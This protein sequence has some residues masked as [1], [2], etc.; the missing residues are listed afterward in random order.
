MSDADS[1]SSKESPE[2]TVKVDDTRRPPR[3]AYVI[4]MLPLRETVVFPYMVIPLFVGRPKSLRAIDRSMET[5]R[6]ILVVSQK[7]A[8]IDE[9]TVNDVYQVG[10]VC[11]IMQMLKL[12]DGII[13][14]L[15][16][17]LYRAR[18]KDYVETT[19]LF[20][21]NAEEIPDDPAST[22]AL[23]A[24][25]K[26]VL[27][28]FEQYIKLNKKIP[29]EI[30]QVATNIDDPGRM[31][32]VVT[33]HLN[34][35]V[36]V[37]QEILEA[38]SSQKRLEILH[39]LLNKEIE[40]LN[41]EKKIRGRVRK[42]TETLQ[43][44]AYLREQMRAIQKELGD[45]DQ[46]LAEIEEYKKK[47]KEAKMHPVAE[48][49]SLS[50]LDKLSK[51]AASSAEAG[52]IRNYL[53]IMLELPWSISTKDR[54]NIPRAEKILNQDHFGLEEPKARILEHLS[55][56]KLKRTIKGPIVCLLGPPGVGKTSLARSVARAMGRKF[57]RI[58]LGGMRD[59]AEIR[60][61]RKTYVGA[62]PGRIIQTLKRAGSNN[63][64]IL[65]DEIDK[66]GS[67]FKGDPA[68]ALLEVLDPEQN[69]TFTDHYLGVAF[70]LSHV[71]FLTTANQPHTIPEPLR[72]RM[73]IIS[74]PGYTEEE[75]VGI[76]ERH[77]VPKQIQE[78]GLSRRGVEFSRKALIQAVRYYTREAGVREL[79]RKIGAICRKIAKEIVSR[80]KRNKIRLTEKSVRKYLG[81]PKYQYGRTEEK[82][83]VGVVMG[84]AWTQVGGV[85]L[86]IE[87]IAMRG[88]GKLMLTGQLGKVMQESA[89][90]AVSFTRKNHERFSI[91][92]DFYKKVDLHINAP[93]GATPKDGPS[94]GVTIATAV[95]SSLTSTP[96]SKDIA[97][98]GE[99][100][101]K[102]KVLPVGGIK[103]K[104]LAA[105][106]LGIRTVIL[107]AEN[108]K[109]LE[110]I[111][112]K[113]QR[114][115]SFHLVQRLD[116]VIAL[117]F[118]RKNGAPAPLPWLSERPPRRRK[119]AHTGEKS[120]EEE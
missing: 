87:A 101:L 26:Q 53:D 13:K 98:T 97:M 23:E 10:T 29:A 107:P 37:K 81:A 58:S 65:L 20:E 28:S 86:Q 17:G 50:E 69:S 99:V 46:T 76:G 34:L 66:T 44:D 91:P 16:E 84:L 119:P 21:V 74:L 18:L 118:V 43:K 63:P 38:F 27:D 72:D 114:Q 85:P 9:P 77:L 57:A 14:I 78:N 42:Q 19:E 31:A 7:A 47:I 54:L 116:E 83:E 110:E 39:E 49:K 60:G 36:E 108:R 120:A 71:L 80:K 92:K 75:K 79:E 94:A 56:C 106:R 52:V 89:Q 64:V 111:P 109:N 55:V 67:D 15:V 33:A 112:K 32:D 30:L 41:V 51:M 70:D 3:G 25:K 68:S 59:E 102:G 6:E 5:G 2:A 100:T 12:P 48:E 115:M 88:A 11:Q 24:L 113:I 73:E 1:P 93:E 95:I 104:V 61:H 22:P 90:A 103:E 8:T 40:I 105:F 4:P 35:K 45:S 96:V 62:M 82:D 117:A